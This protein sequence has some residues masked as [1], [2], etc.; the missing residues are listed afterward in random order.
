LKLVLNG[1]GAGLDAL[2]ITHDIQNSQRPLPA[3][4]EGPNTITVSSDDEGTVTIEGSCSLHN[5]GKQILYSDFHP[6]TTNISDDLLRITSASGDVT[7][8]IS[9]PG[10]MTRLRIG[11]FYRA[12]DKKDRWDVEVSFDGSKTYRVVEKLEGPTVGSGRYMVVADVPPGARAAL[13]RLAGYQVN[14]TMLYN[15]RIDAD[16]KEPYGGFAPFQV[17]YNW[18]EHGEPREDV[19]IV[20][21][22]D[23][24]YHIYCATPPVMKSIILERPTGGG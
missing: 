20:R 6:T 9:T 7:F 12:R 10:D 8:P 19:H 22:P 17:K 21:S 2:K 15:L 14:T 23:E 18:M 11:A 3:L 1:K 4:T 5:K 13:V 16:Y 24:V